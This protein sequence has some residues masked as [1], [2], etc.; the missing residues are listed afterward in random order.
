MLLAALA[1]IRSETRRRLL[2]WLA[3]ALVF[4]ILRLGLLSNAQRRRLPK[5][6]SPS[7]RPEGSSP[8][9]SFNHFGRWTISMPERSFLLRFWLVTDWRMYCTRFRRAAASSLF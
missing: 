8:H 3:L 2:P 5:H 1:F 9:R 7:A 4:L 6:Y